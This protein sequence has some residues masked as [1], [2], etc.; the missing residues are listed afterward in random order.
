VSRIDEVL[1][2]VLRAP[3]PADSDREVPQSSGQAHP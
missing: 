3:E 1:A 2:L